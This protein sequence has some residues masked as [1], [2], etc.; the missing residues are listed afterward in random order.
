MVGNMNFWDLIVEKM[1]DKEISAYKVSQLTGVPYTTIVS[2]RN[3]HQPTIEKADKI[4]SALGI[5]VTLG[6]AHQ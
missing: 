1:G 3:G 5:T 4:L 6:E 2:Y